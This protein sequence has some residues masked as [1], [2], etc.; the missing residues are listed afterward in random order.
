MTNAA[1][2]GTGRT[3]WEVQKDFVA[4]FVSNFEV[5]LDKVR[6]RALQYNENLRYDWNWEDGDSVEEITQRTSS[7]T[8]FD[9]SSC[10]TCSRL[11]KAYR[12][13]ES[14]FE[15]ARPDA[16]KFVLAFAD[17][18]NG[19][20]GSGSNSIESRLSRGLEWAESN[21]VEIFFVRIGGSWANG[22][23]WADF[24]L[25]ES[26]YMETGAA[27]WNALEA[28]APQISNKVCAAN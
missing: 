3:K 2:D 12:N 27:G 25:T 23:T 20:W 10:S 13:F 7:I 16:S 15:D 6:F 18:I 11:A 21:D 28:I 19:V 22:M 4:S 1:D 14:L 5:G 9:E 17:G 26:S 8:Q 24:A